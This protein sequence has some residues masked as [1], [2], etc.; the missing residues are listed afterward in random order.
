M[1]KTMSYFEVNYAVTSYKTAY[2]AIDSELDEDVAENLI[3]ESIYDIDQL[4]DKRSCDEQIHEND[5]DINYF[6]DASETDD[7]EFV[8]QSDIADNLVLIKK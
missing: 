5:I 6:G 7:C 3:R 4:S 8:I 2:V 1:N